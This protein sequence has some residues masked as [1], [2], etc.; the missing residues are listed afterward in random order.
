MTANEFR[1]LALALPGAVESA[2]MDHPEFRVRGRIFATLGAPDEDFGMVK[3]TPEEQRSFV[4]KEPEVFKPC[5]GTWGR[6]GCTYVHL[7]SA[8]GAL[9]RRALDAAFQNVA[10]QAMIRKPKTMS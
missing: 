6:Q 8:A 3:L 9:A 4:D 2:H 7:P 1:S 5:S 10:A